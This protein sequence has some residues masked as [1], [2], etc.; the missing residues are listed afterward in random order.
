[1]QRLNCGNAP[2]KTALCLSTPK[3]A[4]SYREVPLCGLALQLCQRFKEKEKS[5][6]LL[7]GNQNIPD[8]RTLQYRFAKFAADC[9]LAGVHFHTLRHSFATRLMELGIDV[10]TVSA[11]LGH[12]SARTTLDFYG[13][14]LSERQTHA[15]ALLNAC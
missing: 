5:A 7:T 12:Q 11:L 13:H 15:A 8:P 4:N 3:S 6:Y 9:N 2:T 1:M 10:Q 14:S